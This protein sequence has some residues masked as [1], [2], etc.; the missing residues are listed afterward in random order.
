MAENI[1]NLQRYNELRQ[2]YRDELLRSVDPTKAL[3]SDLSSI[4]SF[5]NKVFD[6]RS[7]KTNKE[8]A[9]KLLS[10]PSD[11]NYNHT[12]GPFMSAL[13]RNRHAHVV[14][15]FIKESKEELLM[16]DSYKLL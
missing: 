12:I 6:I 3:L 4:E 1:P 15:V 13:R 7:T 2:K 16:D 10:L 8:A 11:K 9:D 5:K 14:S